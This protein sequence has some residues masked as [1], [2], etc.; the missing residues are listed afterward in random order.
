MC[1]L[2]E[3]HDEEL[4]KEVLNPPKFEEVCRGLITRYGRLKNL[5][6]KFYFELRSFPVMR[7]LT[8]AITQ[9]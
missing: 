9:T 6:K 7:V 4:L 3:Q 1:N 5:V 2:K 8:A